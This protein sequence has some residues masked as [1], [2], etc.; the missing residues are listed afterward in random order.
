M[1]RAGVVLGAVF[2]AAVHLGGCSDKGSPFAPVE[3]PPDTPPVQA[4]SC[5]GCHT[6]YTLLKQIASPDTAK[7]P[8]GCGGDV[9]HI[10]PYDRVFMGGSGYD[11]F[12]N[13]THG[14][15]SCTSCHGG[16]ENTADKKQAHSGAFVKNPSRTN[17][18]VCV[19]CHSS[20]VSRFKTS[21]HYQ[22][23]GQKN[24]IVRRMGVSSFDAL[25]HG[26][27]GAYGQNCATCHASCGDCHVNRPIAG[28]GGLLRGHKFQRTPDM[29]DNCTTCHSSRG[30]HAFFGIGAGTQPDAHLKAGFTCLRC[31]EGSSLHGDG[32]TYAH[33]FESRT[34][35]TCTGCHRGVLTSSENDYHI[36]HAS[37]LTCH[38]CHSQNYNN[39]GSCHVGG[40]GVRVASHLSFRMALNPIPTLRT[41]RIVPV[42]RAP[43]APDSWSNFGLAQLTAFDAKATYNYAAPHNI[44]L[45]TTRT[46]VAAGAACYD[47]CHIIRDG[48]TYR[49]REL[50]L[51]EADLKEPWEKS[52]SRHLAVD[53]KLPANWNVR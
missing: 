39:C 16:V 36:A 2:A 12:R 18:D 3:P 20:I 49:N 28:G 26:V 10:E 52:A 13:S 6:N 7:V 46:K 44:Q 14:R 48:D 45:W 41:A 15:Q 17:P 21:L 22:G 30:G 4:A 40:S 19:Q 1:R 33:R 32:T 23:W 8:G 51:F 43:A 27:Q 38:T 24:S 29:R 31:H 11:D 50:Y 47:S 25:P 53:G 37:D 34:L 42:R 35:P 5:A 9:P